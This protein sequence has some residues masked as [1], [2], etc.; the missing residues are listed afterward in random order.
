MGADRVILQEIVEISITRRNA[1][2]YK[3]LGYAIPSHIGYRGNTAMNFKS[4]IQVKV[5]HIQRNTKVKVLCKC[6][7]CGKERL[8]SYDSMA[9]REN[10]S[11]LKTG[12][13]LCGNCANR[14]MSGKN[15]GQF[16]H[17][18]NRFC[19]YRNNAKRRGI[20][21][22]LEVQEFE[23]ITNQPC[24]YCG[25]FSSDFNEASRGNGIDRK[26]SNKGYLLDNC[27]PCC[28]TCNFL[29][30]NTPYK[31]FIEYI[32]RVYERTKNYEV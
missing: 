4:I 15:N 29:K 30:N 25:G 21:F 6:E 1:N 9:N 14:R 10:S 5:E 24:H 7:D 23:Q 17:G 28:A 19:E 18:N 20:E 16:K 31:D 12:E 13:T 32:R 22:S 3:K 11:F 8:V 2:H 27:V 26:D